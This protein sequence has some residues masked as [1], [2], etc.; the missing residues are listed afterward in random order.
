[1]VGRVGIRT[2]RQFDKLTT[3]DIV[4][5]QLPG[6]LLSDVHSLSSSSIDVDFLKN[7]D[8]RIRITQEIYDRPKL[9]AAIN[10]PIHYSY[11]TAWP[12]EPLARREILGDELVG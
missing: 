5:A 1:M 6:D 7:E 3:E 9:Q 8:I 11:G 4:Q 2:L 12:G 10:V